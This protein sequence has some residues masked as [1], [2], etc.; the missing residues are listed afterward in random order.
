M[1]KLKISFFFFV[2]RVDFRGSEKSEKP[3]ILG[4][5]SFVKKC[6]GITLIFH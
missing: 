3:G 6:Q 1:Q 2:L 4:Q 5:L